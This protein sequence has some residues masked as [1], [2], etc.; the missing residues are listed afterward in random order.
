MPSRTRPSTTSLVSGSKS[1]SASS[2]EWI[3]SRSANSR[4]ATAGSAST[5]R[6]YCRTASST[7]P[8]CDSSRAKST[9]ARAGGFGR[10]VMSSRITMARSF[11]PCWTKAL[12]SPTLRLAS[13]G[14]S[15]RASRNSASA[16]SGRPCAR[17]LSARCRLKGIFSGER[18][19][20][21]RKVSRARSLLTANSSHK[22]SILRDQTRKP[23]VGRRL[24]MRQGDRGTILGGPYR[25]ERL[26]ESA[27]DVSPTSASRRSC[28]H[29][30]ARVSGAQPEREVPGSL[31]PAN[32]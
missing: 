12:A 29:H 28:A 6:W 17:R 3:P 14:A 19:T 31:A 22:S 26:D 27:L 30:T 25:G 5:P 20:A 23:I 1:R 15:V 8:A 7:S 24:T 9:K 2:L 11:F 18:R 4:S 16:S 10:L 13:S 32:R 21:S